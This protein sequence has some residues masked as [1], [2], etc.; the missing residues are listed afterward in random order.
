MTTRNRI[1]I[2]F[3]LALLAACPLG[4]ATPTDWTAVAAREAPAWVR[5]AVIYEVFP[6]QF[7]QKGDFASI[8]A[9]LDELKALGIDVLWLMPVH[10]IGHLRSKGSIGSPYAVRDYYA[11]NPDY[12]TK[13]DLHRLIDG[14]HARGM[15]VIIDM[16][17]N[18]TAWDSVM[19][20]HPGYYKQDGAGHVISPHP[21]WSDVAALNYANP[22]TRRYM[23]AMME[24]WVREFHVDG[25]RC[26]V[27]AEV[28]TDFWE[29]LR[30]DLDQLQPGLFLLA[31]SD[32]PELLRKAFDADYAWPMMSTLNRVLMEGAPASELR[33]TWEQKER[34]AF[35]RGSLHMRCSDNHDEARAISRFGWNGALAASAMMMTLDGIPLVYNG[36]EVG[37]STESGDPA[38][39]EKVPILWQP[40]QRNSFR[41]TYTALIALR[42]KHPALCGGS[43]MWLEN[44]APENVVS[45]LRRSEG[46]EIVTLVN[47]SNRPQAVSVQLE[48]AAKFSLLLK[49]GPSAVGKDGLPAASLGAYEWLIFGRALSP[50]A[51]TAGAK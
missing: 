21:G 39:F 38:L 9:R 25:F 36:M 12:G 19:M 33:R 31:E 18:H 7:S 13:D 42:H 51:G 32:N 28:P 20:S 40:K 48:E 1:A 4:A 22:E 14:S 11:V 3:L 29:E 24:Y 17:A 41:A 2:P 27:A 47:F 43:M 49:R 35:P 45:F 16:V 34:A 50:R 30:Q 8:T 37:D 44:S 10:P 46:E 15:R 26:D 23:I 5:S 6:R